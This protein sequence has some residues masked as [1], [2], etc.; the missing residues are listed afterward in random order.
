MPATRVSKTAE[1]R[2]EAEGKKAGNP[3]KVKKSVVDAFTRMIPEYQVLNKKGVGK[4]TRM[5]PFWQTATTVMWSLMTME[6][7]RIQVRAMPDDDDEA[8][9][10]AIVEVS[11]AR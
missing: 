10:T 6:E 7:A 2:R 5:K 9:T 1:E 8:V 11:K 3:G 4:I